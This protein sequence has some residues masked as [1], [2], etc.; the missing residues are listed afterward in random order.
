MCYN[1]RTE[2]KMAIVDFEELK[3]DDLRRARETSTGRRIGA[4]G[5]LFL[6]HIADEHSPTF[7]GVKSIARAEIRRRAALEA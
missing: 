7:P 5:I 2:A 6:S 4:V 1:L 3:G